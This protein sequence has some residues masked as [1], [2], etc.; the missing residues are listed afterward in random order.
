[1]SP[2]NGVVLLIISNISFMLTW[3]DTRLGGRP[4][5]VGDTSEV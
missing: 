2:V 4:S 5:F 3:V 1:M